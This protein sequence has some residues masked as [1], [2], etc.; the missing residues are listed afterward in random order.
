[1]TTETKSYIDKLDE[2]FETIFKSVEIG[3]SEEISPNSIEF[4]KELSNRL[5]ETY[6][7][8]INTLDN[9]VTY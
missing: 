9:N 7:A 3:L 6:E 4:E 1:M 2:L 5:S 8:I